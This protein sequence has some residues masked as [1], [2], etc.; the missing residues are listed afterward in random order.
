MAHIV[1]FNPA[2]DKVILDSPSEDT[3]R[4]VSDPDAV[5]NPDFSAVIGVAQKY[6]K[7]AAGAIVSKTAQEISDQDAAEAAAIIA[8]IKMAAKAH[9]TNTADVDWRAIAAIV[10]DEINVLR[11]RD[12]DRSDDVAAAISLADLKARWALRSSLADRTL[13]QAK[14]AYNN[15]VDSGDAD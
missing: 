12:R 1:K 3:S 13:A 8:A 14:T 6:W 9:M 7:L 15:K 5:I 2:H 11:Q 10:I 4:Y